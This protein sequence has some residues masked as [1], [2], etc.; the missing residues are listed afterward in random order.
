MRVTLISRMHNIIQ[1]QS[2]GEG[3]QAGTQENEHC[4]NGRVLEKYTTQQIRQRGD[5]MRCIMQAV[6]KVL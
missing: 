5:N 2:T 4:Q 1:D 6:G 3:E